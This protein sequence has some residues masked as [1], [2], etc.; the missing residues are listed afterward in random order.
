MTT[1]VP[2][3]RGGGQLRV[4]AST[5]SPEDFPA[6]GT[7]S[8][9]ADAEPA[10]SA[11]AGRGSATS[12]RRS[13]RRSSSSK[14]FLDSSG[15]VSSTS[16]ATL[17]TCGSMRGGIA[18][19]RPPWAR[20]TSAGD[21]F[22]LLLTPTASSYDRARGGSSSR[23]PIRPSLDTMARRGLWPTPTARLGSRRGAPSPAHAWRRL[24]AG[25]SNLE[26]VV[27][28]TNRGPLNPAWI[29][30]LMG[31]PTGWT[32][33]ASSVTPSSPPSASTSATGCAPR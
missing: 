26:D 2:A 19:P 25:R 15:P 29:E 4:R 1:F 7:R 12:S 10:T 24:R 14:T 13:S 8:P 11:G 23:G 17:P 30:W 32:D 20:R 22:S 5:S 3:S 33:C 21:L 9:V 18:F 31:F 28:T 16:C 27:A 6:R